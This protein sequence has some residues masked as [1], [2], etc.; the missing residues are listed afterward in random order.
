MALKQVRIE[1]AVTSYFDALRP[2]RLAGSTLRQKARPIEALRDRAKAEGVVYVRDLTTDHFDMTMIDLATGRMPEGVAQVKGAPRRKRDLTTLRKDRSTLLR[3]AN[4]CKH[5]RWMAYSFSPLFEAASKSTR[6]YGNDMGAA[7]S[8]REV[9]AHEDWLRLLEIAGEKHPRARI[10][11]AVALFTG[12]RVSEVTL[13]QWGHVNQAAREINVLNQKRGRW[14][15]IAY[16]GT[17]ASELHRWR[18]WVT[19]HYGVPQPGW[20]IIPPRVH[21][22]DLYL[23]GDFRPNSKRYSH[24]EWP[25][26]VDRKPTIGPLIAE[27]QECL[28]RLGWESTH[29]EGVHTLRRSLARF[30]DAKGRLAEAQ[31]LFDHEGINMTKA[32]AGDSAGRQRLADLMEENGGD[33]YGLGISTAPRHRSA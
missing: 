11:I 20:Y 3:F 15:T 6:K 8:P 16:E 29:K 17:L 28:R 12:R 33:P 1:A 26:Q 2:A 32:Y 21:T 31:T 23:V 9:V 5:H 14:F 7:E 19:E 18:K 4:F 25:L 22:R 27:V 24:S 10:L 30:L 13:M